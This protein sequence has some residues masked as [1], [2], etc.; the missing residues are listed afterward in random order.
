MRVTVIAD[1]SYDSRYKVGGYGYWIASERG[2]RP[3]GGPLRGEI[4][5]SHVAEMMAICRA[6]HDGVKQKLIQPGDNVLIQTDCIGAIASLNRAVKSKAVTLP[7][8]EKLV[9]EVFYELRNKH[10]LEVRFRHVKGHTNNEEARFA[11][12]RACDARAKAGMRIERTK[13]L[14]ESAHV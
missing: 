2:K 3:G 6:V 11:A 13:R 1:A 14:K 12:N 7:A 4:F 10:K 8:E 5:S 9:C